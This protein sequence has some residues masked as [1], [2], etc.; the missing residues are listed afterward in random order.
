MGPWLLAAMVLESVSA[1]M[2]MLIHISQRRSHVLAWP[3]SHWT[4]NLPDI[5]HM[6]PKVVPIRKTG[7]LLYAC[8]SNVPSFVMTI[9]VSVRIT[10]ACIAW[11]ACVMWQVM[12]WDTATMLDI[13][14]QVED[15]H[16]DRDDDCSVHTAIRYCM[17]PEY[18]AVKAPVRS[19]M[20]IP[21]HMMSM[22]IL[23]NSFALLF[24]CSSTCSSFRIMYIFFCIVLPSFAILS[25]LCMD[26]V[27]LSDSVTRKASKY[28]RVYAIFSAEDAVSG[29]CE[30][31]KLNKLFTSSVLFDRTSE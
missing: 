18:H 16:L 11:S 21:V 15:G 7:M 31:T 4:A 1:A 30:S 22:V 27:A 29:M 12:A 13:M 26:D 23:E 14:L 10:R 2:K 19:M 20:T 6:M 5:P 24:I 8:E 17:L 3:P 28:R 25:I 9:G